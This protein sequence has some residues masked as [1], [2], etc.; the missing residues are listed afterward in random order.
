MTIKRTT[1]S[2][3][4]INILLTL[5]FLLHLLAFVPARP[6]AA[7]PRQIMDAVYKQDNSRDTTWRAS[8]ETTGKNGTVRKKK[9]IFQKLGTLG[10][11]KTLARFTDPAEVRGVGLLSWNQGGAAD[12]QWMYTPAINRTRRI[13][14]QER[15]RKFLGTDFSN[16]DMAERVLDDFTYKLVSD[17]ETMD[18]RKVYKIEA[19]PVSP[20]RSQYSQIYMWV[21]QDIPVTLYAQMYDDKGTRVREYHATQLEKI[22]GVWVARR[23]E[24]ST[25]SENTRTVMILDEVKFNTSLKEDQFTQQALEKPA[26]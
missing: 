7:D 13:A 18:G 21:A 26:M 3:Q 25:P 9:F 2:R 8:M 23:L 19:R 17:S 6:R 22:S 1:N 24:I 11:S 5:C 20:D 14:P 16:E 15:G 10:N 12:R 4:H